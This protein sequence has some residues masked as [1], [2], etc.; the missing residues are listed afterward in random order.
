[1]ASG[2]GSTST[3]EGARRSAMA[4]SLRPCP[5]IVTTSRSPSTSPRSTAARPAAE[6]GS[7]KSPSSDASVRHAETISSSSTWTRGRRGAHRLRVHRVSDPDRRGEGLPSLLGLDRDDRRIEA[8]LR[9]RLRVGR[10]VA[11]STVR[12]DECVRRAAEL[13]DDLQHRGL[14]PGAPVRVQ[15]VD[16][17]VG[18]AARELLGR[19]ER[20]VEVAS[21]LEHDR[22]QHPRLGELPP[23]TAPCG[24]DHAG[25]PARAAY[26]AALAAV[27]PVEAQST[28]AARSSSAFE[29]ASVIPR[30]L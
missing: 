27:F 19:C 24:V 9:A 15:G 10:G 13:L 17:H 26:A 30:S 16:E 3:G 21:H 11:A 1:M 28:A 23:A 7:Q 8:Q 6:D 5:V 25:M 29:T 18:S 12:E 2:S 4:G 14:L 22:A 20:G